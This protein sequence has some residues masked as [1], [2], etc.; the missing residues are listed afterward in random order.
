[1]TIPDAMPHILILYKPPAELVD[2]LDVTRVKVVSQRTVFYDMIQAVYGIPGFITEDKSLEGEVFNGLT[3]KAI[4]S[5]FYR[6][7]KS[8][9]TLLLD[10]VR[11]VVSRDSVYGLACA[12]ACNDVDYVETVE[13]FEAREDIIVTTVGFVD[14]GADVGMLLDGDIDSQVASLVEWATELRA[15]D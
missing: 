11:D 4:K 8:Q 5:S 15:G 13:F 3:L 2:R 6:F 12:I 10:R 14:S 9:G 7:I 1:M